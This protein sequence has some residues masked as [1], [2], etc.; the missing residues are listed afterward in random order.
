MTA[1]IDPAT[2]AAAKSRPMGRLVILDS[3]RFVAAAAVLFQHGV[4]QQGAIGQRI[5]AALSPGVFGVALFFLISGFVIPMSAGR[6]FDLRSFAIRRM[7]RIYPLVLVTFA[8]V[9][10]L[11]RLTPWPAFETARVGSAYDWAANL[12][13]IQD[14][15]GAQS[16]HG[17]TWTLSLELAWY[18][19]FA[20]MM[21][22]RGDR[23]AE[24]LL[25]VLPI[26][27]LGAAALSVAIAHRIP[28]ARP[29][30]V[31]AAVLGCRTYAYHTGRL[32]GRTL[33]IEAIIFTSVMT[34]CNLV[35]FGHFVHPTI[36][37]GQAVVPWLAA[38][39]FF[40]LV[41][42]NN[43]IRTSR[44]FDNRPLSWLGAMSFSIYLLH[45][46]ALAAAESVTTSVWSLPLAL[47]LTL[48]L[49]MLAYRTIELPAI[50]LARRLTP[51]AAATPV[52]AAEAA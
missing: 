19:L 3:L 35:S 7:L 41:M 2:F 31:Y 21:A 30:M 1:I 48:L 13:L 6:R 51:R 38:T 15:V 36:T 45:P 50:A 20:A 26:A 17:V 14:Y 42:T 29:G 27:L 47:G 22:W 9:A 5:V 4:E 18:G 10:I 52:S 39:A 46:I 44:I 40:M 23:F 11:G 33:A 16:I 34:I 43:A 12:L 24:P 32:T 28:L 8:V 37:L 49:S 25:I